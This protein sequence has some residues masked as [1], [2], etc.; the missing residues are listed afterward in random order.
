MNNKIWINNNFNL[1]TD[2]E[3]NLIMYSINK[4]NNDNLT[5]T[6]LIDEITNEFDFEEDPWDALL[7]TVESLYEKS[8]QLL[9]SVNYRWILGYCCSK[10]KK[11]VVIDFSP[12]FSNIKSTDK[13]KWS[14]YRKEFIE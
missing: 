3:K 11:H 7:K 2:E 4:I 5:V 9:E 10:N 6:I 13:K 14:V 8:F 12:V 1:L